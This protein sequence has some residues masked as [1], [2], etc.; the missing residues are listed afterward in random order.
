MTHYFLF[1]F[2]LNFILLIVIFYFR[3]EIRDGFRLRILIRW[4]DYCK[5]RIFTREKRIRNYIIRSHSEIKEFQI[6]NMGIY[7]IDPD[8]AYFEGSI[9]VYTY[10]EDNFKPLDLSNYTNL[11]ESIKADPT[12]VDK[13][14]LRAKA[15][16]RLAEW[17][18]QQKI[19]LIVIIVGAVI[20]L[21]SAYF[22]F[23]LYKFFEPYISSKINII[24]DDLINR[25]AQK[26][27]QSCSTNTIIA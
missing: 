14:V 20:S 7:T 4:F 1:A 27:A 3:F 2:A 24:L 8:K 9:P 6:E 26:C 22:I 21:I 12:L 13:V 5:V 17:F 15:S 23:K 10:M 18:K 19:M 11:E 25:V 16:G